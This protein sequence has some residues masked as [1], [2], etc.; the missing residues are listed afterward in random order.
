MHERQESYSNQKS[1]TDQP[2]RAFECVGGQRRHHYHRDQIDEAFDEE[3][4]EAIN[5]AYTIGFQVDGPQ[6]LTDLSGRRRKPETGKVYG[7]IGK[8]RHAI[9]KPPEIIIP[10]QV[11]QEI[12]DER[13]AQHDSP[14]RPTEHANRSPDFSGVGE[15]C[16]HAEHDDGEHTND[17]ELTQ[18]VCRKSQV[19]IRYAKKTGRPDATQLRQ[20]SSPVQASALLDAILADRGQ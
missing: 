6:C 18:K 13:Q 8:H 15:G 2:S 5:V 1:Q 4:G 10:A 16:K 14:P 17:R 7:Q 11:T 19:C 9:P 3:C 12:I 20:G